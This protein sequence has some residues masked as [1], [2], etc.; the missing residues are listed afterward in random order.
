MVTV[1]LPKSD[2]FAA[3]QGGL[4][5]Q[6]WMVLYASAEVGSSKLDGSYVREVNGLIK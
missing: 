1:S 5:R 3:L 2:R 6:G 4:Q